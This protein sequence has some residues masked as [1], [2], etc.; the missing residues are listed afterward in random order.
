VDSIDH[1]PILDPRQRGT[2]SRLPA[3][4]PQIC[5]VERDDRRGATPDPSRGPPDRPL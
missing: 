3:A 5:T 1:A 2:R 4:G